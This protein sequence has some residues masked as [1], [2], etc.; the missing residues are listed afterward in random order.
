MKLQQEQNA[1]ILEAKV[2][3]KINNIIEYEIPNN[4]ASIELLKEREEL[5]SYMNSV[6][7][8]TYK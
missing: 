8:T 4:T 7:N 2:V 1:R 6:L 5:I 3:Q